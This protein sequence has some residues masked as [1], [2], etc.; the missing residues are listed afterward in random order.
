M[1][2]FYFLHSSFLDT[3]KVSFY[4]LHSSFLDMAF[5]NESYFDISS[6]FEVEKTNAPNS[7]E[8]NIEGQIPSL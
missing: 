4:Y 6:V 8:T 1:V 7:S 2:S 5:F 3:A